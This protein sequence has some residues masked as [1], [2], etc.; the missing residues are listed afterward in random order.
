MTTFLRPMVRAAAVAFLTIT[1]LPSTLR[2]DDPAKVKKQLERMDHEFTPDGFLKA[3]DDRDVKAVRLFLAGGMDIQSHNS[4]GETALHLAAKNDDAEMVSL[5]LKSKPDLNAKD[6]RG[7]TPLYASATNGQGTAKTTPLLLAAGAD[8]GIRYQ[9]GTSIL[10]EAVNSDNAGTV[11]ALIKG[12]AKL[13]AA[14]EK[15]ETPLYLSASMGRKVTPLLIQAG[16]NLN[17]RDEDGETP[18]IGAAATGELES[19]RLLTAAKADA[20]AADKQGRT[21][22][23]NAAGITAA[24]MHSFSIDEGAVTKMV[25]LLLDAGSD[26]KA[27]S[28]Y[29]GIT[30]LIAAAREGHADAVAI[31]L[32]HKAPLNGKT[33]PD[34]YTAL[35]E[36]AKAGHA[37]VVKLLLDAGADPKIKDHVGRSAAKWGADYPDVVA[38]LGGA[39][40]SSKAGASSKSGSPAPRAAAKTVSPEQKAAAQ[41]KLEELGYRYFNESYFVMSATKGEVE[42]AQAF[43]DYGLSVDSKDPDDHTTTPLLRAAENDDPALGLFLIEHGAN[44]NVM[45]Q[46]GSTPLLL[47]ASHCGQT[48]LLKA[49]LKAGAKVNVKAAGGATPYMMADI[50]KC[51]A[52]ARVLKAAGGK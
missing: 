3:V 15:G 26:V 32:A 41:A 24:Q 5:L 2:A 29:E 14:N 49:L 31:L 40:S 23:I 42:A 4:S 43:L 37:D 34:G 45:D 38:L 19:I 7:R 25:E 44:V 17:A 8:L 47:A 33:E 9:Y 51:S 16:A 18:L 1:L 50:M 46:N 35:M 27:K 20:T 21:A 28:K 12:G 48:P 13:E 36:A 30:P 6:D 10:Y 22:L 39:P 11:Q 52:N